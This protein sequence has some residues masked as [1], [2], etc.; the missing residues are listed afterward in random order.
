MNVFLKNLIAIFTVIN[1][2]INVLTK[3][4]MILSLDCDDDI[5]KVNFNYVKNNLDIET[6][7]L[8]QCYTFS[9]R[10]ENNLEISILYF[11]IVN[12]K[13]IKLKEGFKLVPLSNFNKE[14]IYMAK[15]I[16][17]LKSELSFTST[18]KKIY[19]GEFKLTEIQRLYEEIFGKKYDRRNFRKKLLKLDLIE[20]LNK[21]SLNTTGRPA[22]LYRF[23]DFAENK[24]LF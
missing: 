14:D 16:E 2:E 15:A 21:M 6:L 12:Y 1:G 9:K 5:E 20:D 8:K 17:C 18:I 10:K 23:K 22:K 4:N 13:Y 24:L 7:N 19:P 3:E 11:D